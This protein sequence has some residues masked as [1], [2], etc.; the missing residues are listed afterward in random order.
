MKWRAAAWGGR[1]SA[2]GAAATNDGK[3]RRMRRWPKLEGDHTRMRREG[4]G[5]DGEIAQRSSRTPREADGDA[6]HEAG[7]RQGRPNARRG[8][9]YPQETM[10]QPHRSGGSP[11]QSGEAN[12]HGDGCVARARPKGESAPPGHGA[13][14]RGEGRWRARQT[15]AWRG[16]CG[17]QRPAV[18]PCAKRLRDARGRHGPPRRRRTEAGEAPAAIPRR[19]C[20]RS[21][22]TGGPGGRPCPAA[23][24]PDASAA[25]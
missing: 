11:P 7:P 1:G 24:G 18:R 23:A 20:G 12:R 10:A 25:P 22:G 6:H 9:A 19:R 4:G 2:D 8:A 15:E 13:R 17:L 16:A 3:R 14:G 5:G 21:P